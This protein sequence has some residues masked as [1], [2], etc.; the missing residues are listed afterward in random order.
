MKVEIYNGYFLGSA[1]W[2]GPQEVH[3]EME[4]P[5]ARE[6]FQRYFSQED[7]FLEGSVDCPELSSERHDDTE[8]TFSRALNGL[9]WHNYRA[10]APGEGPGKT[11]EGSQT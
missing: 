9:T 5:T 4:D 7:S 3:L 11:K 6:W 2:R 10:Y 8:E 1:E